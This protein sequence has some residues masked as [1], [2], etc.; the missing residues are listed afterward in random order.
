MPKRT[1]YES[2]VLIPTIVAETV[3]SE[4]YSEQEYSWKVRSLDR[5]A[6]VEE[7]RKALTPEQIRQFADICDEKCRGAYEARADW[8]VKCAKSKSRT[9]Y[10]QLC[11]YIRHWMAAFLNDPQRFVEHHK[12]DQEYAKRRLAS[13]LTI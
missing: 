6:K 10:D 9:G 11:V 4:V 12:A 13:P 5:A 2:L 1:P 8:F 3:C 7:K